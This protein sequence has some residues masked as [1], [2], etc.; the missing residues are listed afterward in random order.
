MRSTPGGGGSSCQ[1]LNLYVTSLDDG[2]V[3]KDFL[4]YHLLLP[5]RFLCSGRRT[6]LT[7]PWTRPGTLGGSSTEREVSSVGPVPLVSPVVGPRVPSR[8]TTK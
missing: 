7:G 6:G 4:L 2:L 3:C 1:S 8:L 5:V